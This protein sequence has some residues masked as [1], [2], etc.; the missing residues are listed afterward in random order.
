MIRHLQRSTKPLIQ[1]LPFQR[2]VRDFYA[3]ILPLLTGIDSI[4]PLPSSS[5]SS[6]NG[7]TLLRALEDLLP[8]GSFPSNLLHLWGRDSD[9]ITSLADR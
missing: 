7:K 3:V 2:L 6:T 9:N 4:F 1:K 5:P 8:M